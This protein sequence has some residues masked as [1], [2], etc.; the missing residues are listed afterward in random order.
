MSKPPLA[1]FGTNIDPQITNPLIISEAHDAAAKQGF[2]TTPPNQ[3]VPHP[4]DSLGPRT[5]TDS[6]VQVQSPLEQN[7]STSCNQSDPRQDVRMH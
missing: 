2:H 3:F 4:F 7:D 5:S 1:F 6:F